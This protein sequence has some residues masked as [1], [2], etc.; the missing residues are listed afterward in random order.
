MVIRSDL[1]TD[2]LETASEVIDAVGGTG[3]AAVL[4]AAAAPTG[5]CTAQSVSNWRAAGRF[6]PQT[7]LVFSAALS[8]IGKSAPPSLWSMYEPKA[9]SASVGAAS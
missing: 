1:A 3:E 8:A 2:F 5:K 6:P 4:V 9:V 7:Y